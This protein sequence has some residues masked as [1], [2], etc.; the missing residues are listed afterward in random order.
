MSQTIYELRICRKKSTLVSPFEAHHVRK[1]NTALTNAN[2]KPHRT[3]LDWSNTIYSYLDNN[4][5]EQEDL[6][7]DDRWELE[8]LDSD[9]EVKAA[10][11]KKLEEAKSDKGEVPR[12]FKL[13]SAQFEEPLA[14][15]SPRLQL[16]RQTN[17]TNRSKKHLQGLYDAVPEGTV[18]VKTTDATLTLKVPGQKETVLNKADVAKFGTTE[19]RNIPLIN[20]VARKTV[21]NHHSK[22]AQQ[23][24]AHGKQQ[25]DN[26]LGTITIRKKEKRPREPNSKS[27][28]EKVS[29]NKSTHEKTLRRITQKG[30]TH[31]TKNQVFIAKFPRA[32]PSNVHEG[33][34]RPHG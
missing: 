11:A 23:M 20:F 15:T 21:S 34:Y 25:W 8:E 22:L 13:H 32:R 10:K 17:T 12:T 30:E 31:E 9:A 24:E 2:T 7:M 26:I 29:R 14:S 28:L 6:I 3:N 1:P 4:I 18:L 33:R 19:Q 16:A 5:I 27:H